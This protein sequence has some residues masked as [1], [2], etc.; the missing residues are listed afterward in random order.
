M[1]HICDTKIIASLLQDYKIVVLP[2]DTIYGLSGLIHPNNV[3]KISAIKKRDFSKGFIIISFNIHHLFPFIDL[4]KLNTSQIRKF[5]ILYDNPTTWIVPVKKEF[6]WLTGGSS[7][8]AIRLTRNT[9]IS[10]I[11]LMLNQAII[12]TSAN[13]S[14]LPPATNIKELDHYF[15]N[16]LIYFYSKVFYCKSKPSKIIDLVSGNILRK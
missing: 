13:L 4:S 7:N 12:S 1:I 5:S 14:G 9:V 2:T 11:T 8:I 6:F 10:K 3:R 15:N 16:D